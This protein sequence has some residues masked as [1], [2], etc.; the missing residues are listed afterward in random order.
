MGL[1]GAGLC[2]GFAGQNVN[3]I[4]HETGELSPLLVDN[5]GKTIRTVRAWK[6]QRKVIRKRWLDYLGALESNPK[7]P[8]LRVM[9]EREF[10][11]ELGES[12]R[13]GLIKAGSNFQ[14]IVMPV[15][16]D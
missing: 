16:L 9:K 13:P 3:R 15:N 5:N 12:D 1:A 14:Y 7:S 11:L 4:S 2:F 10:S 6:A 8:V